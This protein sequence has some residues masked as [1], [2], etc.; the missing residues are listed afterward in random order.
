[1]GDRDRHLP[2]AESAV[3][4][5]VGRGRPARVTTAQIAEAA[6][7]VG[8]DK[9]TIRNVAK[10]LGM[11]VPGLYHHV[12]TRDDLVAMAVAHS[13]GELV[14][15]VDRG[16]PWTDWLLEYGRFV[17]DAIVDQPEI[18]GQILAGTYNSIREAQ[19]LEQVFAVLERHG[20]SVV[21]AYTI[22]QRFIA[23]VDGAAVMEIGSRA[24]TDAGHT[25]ADDLRRA[26]AALGVDT[27]PHLDELV[28]STVPTPE[29]RAFE[30]AELVLES[31]ARRYSPDRSTT[32]P[33][34]QRGSEPSDTDRSN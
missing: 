24:A 18:I 7:A 2:A 30:T 22:W 13:L 20:F 25:R 6:L 9:A 19:H 4:S 32:A 16:Q 21:D 14:L 8:L 28:S 15:P 1:M 23:A 34:K 10:H 5:A 3:R 17:F 29:H 31:L 12:R 27:V 26:V 33:S 11:S